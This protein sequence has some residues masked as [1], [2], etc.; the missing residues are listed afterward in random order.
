MALVVTILKLWMHFNASVEAY[1]IHYLQEW[2]W[3]GTAVMIVVSDGQPSGIESLGDKEESGCLML[4]KKYNKCA[5]WLH[6]FINIHSI[7]LCWRLYTTKW[8][9]RI[10]FFGVCWSQ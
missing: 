4:T 8:K 9:R 6:Y 2:Q 7:Q 1:W 5:G 3:Q 10:V